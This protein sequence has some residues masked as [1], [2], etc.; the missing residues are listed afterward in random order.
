MRSRSPSRCSTRP[1]SRASPEWGRACA[2]PCG[3]SGRAGRPGRPAGPAGRGRARRARV[4]SC[5]TSAS[6]WLDTNSVVPAA[7]MAREQVADLVDPLRVQPIGGLVQDQQPGLSQQRRRPAPRRCRIPEGVG[8]YRA[9]AHP[10]QPDLLERLVDAPAPARAT[11]LAGG[12]GRRRRPGTRL[13]HGTGGRRRL[14]LRPVS[15]CA[16][17]RRA[18]PRGTCAPITSA[19]ARGREL[20]A[21]AASVQSL[22]CRSRWDLGSR[23]GRLRVRPGR[24]RP[25]ANSSARSAWSMPWDVIIRASSGARDSG[26]AARASRTAASSA[27]AGECPGRASSRGRRL[28][29]AAP[30]AADRV[31]STAARPVPT[32]DGLS[33]DRRPRPAGR[34]GRGARA[35][36]TRANPLP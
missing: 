11:G 12:R 31:R 17:A 30:P 16:G 32:G 15:R 24:C 28:S 36:V 27:V 10:G 7:F 18:G 19:V 4:Q 3:R 1:S 6:R 25:T 21:R 35:G 22:S 14:V 5:S 13:V 26:S 29:P 33:T 20:Q 9:A 2:G 34:A 23:S 8:T